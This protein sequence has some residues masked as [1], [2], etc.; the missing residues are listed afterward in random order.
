VTKGSWES[1]LSWGQNTTVHLGSSPS[2]PIL[3]DRDLIFWVKLCLWY[4]YIWCKH[5]YFQKLFWQYWV[6]ASWEVNLEP[7][8]AGSACARGKISDGSRSKIFYTGW[9]RSIF[10]GSGR[11]SQFMVWVWIWK[12]SPKI[13]QFFSL[14]VKK[15]LFVLESTRIEGGSASYLL[16]V[17]SKL[18]SGP[19]S[20]MCPSFLIRFSKLCRQLF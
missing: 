9:V 18:G 2:S 14:Q 20:S 16:R 15:N 1:T 5:R 7:S 3:I 4:T 6:Y 10:C 12:I 13:F 8:K 17:K 19:I 11:V